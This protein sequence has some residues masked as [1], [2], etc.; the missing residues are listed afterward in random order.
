MA[1][2][3][4]G[5]GRPARLVRGRATPLRDAML[6]AFDAHAAAPGPE[7]QGE[8]DLAF[9]EAHLAGEASRDD[10]ELVLRARR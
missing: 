5:E 4:E 7:A 10:L 8:M 6:A 3:T 9:L 1:D 2:G